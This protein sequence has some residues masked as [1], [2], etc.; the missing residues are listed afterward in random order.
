TMMKERSIRARDGARKWIAVSHVPIMDDSGHVVHVL[1]IVRDVTERRQLEDQLRLTRKLATLGELAGAMAHEIKNPLGII[2]SAAEIVGNPDR[3]ED[4][5]TLAAG[6]IRQEATRLSE[7]LQAFLSFSKPPQPSFRVQSVHRP[8]RQTLIAYQALA[9]QGLTLESNLCTG[10]PLTRIDADQM[11]QVFLNLILNADQAM[12]DG[13]TIWV[14][15]RPAPNGEIEVEVADNG[16][17]LDEA[18]PQSLFEPFYSTKPKGT[19]LGLSIVMQIVGAHH[20]R[21]EAGNRPGGGARFRVF[22]PSVTE[23]GCGKLAA[24][25]PEDGRPGN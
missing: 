5:K 23:D 13:G 25:T 10:L 2:L 3:P 24:E 14:S 11:Q 20:G 17:G 8:L 18:S 12:P 19:G 7:R 9:R 4:Q 15:T 21:V 6:F 1:G 22:L 16:P